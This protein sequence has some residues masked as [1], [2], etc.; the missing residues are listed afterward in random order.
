MTTHKALHDLGPVYLRNLLDWYQPPRSLRSGNLYLLREKEWRLKT[1]GARRFE[2]AAPYLWN[3]V[4]PIELRTIESVDIFKSQLKT[5]LFKI[6]YSNWYLC[7][8]NVLYICIAQVSSYDWY[9]WGL[10]IIIII[11]ISQ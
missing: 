11:K 1:F 5:H 4:L 3:N 6:A 10:L 8:Y 7:F 9:L 2:F